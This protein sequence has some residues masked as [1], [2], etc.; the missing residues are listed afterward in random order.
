MLSFHL[1]LHTVS[2]TAYR[3]DVVTAVIRYLGTELTYGDHY[4]VV[5]RNDIRIPDCLIYLI[6]GKDASF[7]DHEIF[8]HP[9]LESRELDNLAG[10]IQ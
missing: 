6:L 10:F 1:V 7:V 2:Q 5:V 9:V 3:P 8:D 4:A